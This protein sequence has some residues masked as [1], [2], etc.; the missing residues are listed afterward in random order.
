MIDTHVH[1]TFSSDSKMTLK[2]ALKASKEKGIALAITEHLDLNYPIPGSFKFDIMQYFREYGSYRGK[3]LLLGIEMGLTEQFMEE[4]RAIAKKYDFDYVVGS[5]HFLGNY[6]IYLPDFY[7]GKTK[8]EAYEQYFMTMKK[9]ISGE[10]F[11][12][13]LGHI[14]YI[15]RYAPYEDKEISMKEYGDLVDDVLKSVIA[16]DMALEINTR[17]FNSI[18]YVMNIMDIY[19]RFKELGGQYVTIGSDAHKPTVIG[20]NFSSANEILDRTGL[21][22]VYFRNRKMEYV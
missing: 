2:E 19:K 7:E 8:H 16:Y 14:D 10:R 13:S 4:N 22:N 18:S 20:A 5:I 1:T 9:N 6:D 21:K 11:F 12:D 3:D 15:C 17:G